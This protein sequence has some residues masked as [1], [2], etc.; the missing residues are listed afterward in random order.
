MKYVWSASGLVMVGSSI[1]LGKGAELVT[2]Y[3]NYCLCYSYCVY[4]W[5]FTEVNIY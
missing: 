5:A 2:H 4:T 3:N 1:L